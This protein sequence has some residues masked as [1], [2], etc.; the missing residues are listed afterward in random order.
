MA[1]GTTIRT[2]SSPIATEAFNR[3]SRRPTILPRHYQNIR[4]SREEKD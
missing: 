3:I 1:I 2:D 4:A